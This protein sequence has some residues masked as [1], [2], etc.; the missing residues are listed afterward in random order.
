MHSSIHKGN[1]VEE[2]EGIHL[3]GKEILITPH[4]ISRIEI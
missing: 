2:K 1:K 4:K 3:K